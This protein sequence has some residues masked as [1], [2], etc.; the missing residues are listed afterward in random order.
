MS[1]PV[2]HTA[3]GAILFNETC[4]MCLSPGSLAVCCSG[5]PESY[6]RKELLKHN[7]ST[8]RTAEDI[9]SF[10]QQYQSTQDHYPGTSDRH[11][12]LR[13]V[14]RER[15]PML[16]IKTRS[17]ITKK[18]KASRLREISL[19]KLAIPCLQRALIYPLPAPYSGLPFRQQ[20]IADASRPLPSC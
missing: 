9:S 4:C 7:H 10:L 11:V 14:E 5:R 20:Q 16:D 8:R 15:F 6:D 3:G 18:R 17:D 2:R 13:P 19:K 1:R 12:A